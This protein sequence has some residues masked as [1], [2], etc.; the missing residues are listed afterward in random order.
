LHER[1]LLVYSDRASDPASNLKLESEIFERVNGGELPEILRFWVNSPCLVRGPAKTP[2]HGWYNEKLAADLKIP[3]FTRSSGGGVVYHDEGNLNWSFFLHSPGS[4]LAPR[5]AYELGANHIIGALQTLGAAAL[6]APPNRIDVSGHKVSGIAA[7]FTPRALL[8]HG[9]LLL[10]TDLDRLNALCIPP[11]DC[12]PVANLSS[13]VS[14][15]SAGM[16][17]EA[18]T[19]EL[20]KS[21]VD[22]RRVERIDKAS[23]SRE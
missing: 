1:E 20:T 14:G 9:T 18:V 10:S 6:F 4:F 12:P 15:I 16:V 23:P 7:R 22:P 3:I 5:A 19:M 13:W 8:V 17:E 21:G 11:P 2:G